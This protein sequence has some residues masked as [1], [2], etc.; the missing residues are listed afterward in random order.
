VAPLVEAELDRRDPDRARM[1]PTDPAG[2]RDAWD[3]VER[4][5]DGTVERARGLDPALLHESVDDEWSFIE[6]LRH[7]VFA[8]DAWVRRTI[9]GD[10][11]PWGPL[12]L[13]WD[14]MPD[15]PGIPRDREVRPSLEEV[16]ALRRDRMATVRTV[17]DALT[18]ESLAADTEPVEGAGWPPPKRFPVR[19]CLLIVLNE[20][21][22]HRL[23][24]ERDLDA[25]EA[26]APPGG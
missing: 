17:V 26:E 16:L 12:D 19:E 9:L 11:S 15:T 23:F 25:L 21:W 24:A 2:F 8:T 20:E 10:P 5:W 1:R 3:I 7:L 14:E 4:L 6:T 22:H 18:E 13:P